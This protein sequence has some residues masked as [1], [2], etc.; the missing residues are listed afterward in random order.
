VR[1]Y[2]YGIVVFAVVFIGI[3]VALVV[4]TAARNGGAFGFFIGGLFLALGAGRLY[5]LRSRR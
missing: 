1:A 2:R 3:G 4:V 5:L